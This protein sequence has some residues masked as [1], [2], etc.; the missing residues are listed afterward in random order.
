MIGS[1]QTVPVKLSLGARRVGREPARWM[2]IE[3]LLLQQ[4]QSLR[5]DYFFESA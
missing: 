4:T 3:F 2:S 5:P 1:C